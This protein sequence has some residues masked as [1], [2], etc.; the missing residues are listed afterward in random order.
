MGWSRA[1]V[2]VVLWL[3]TVHR[4][5]AAE[6]RWAVEA[7]LGGAWNAPL[8][9][10]VRQAGHPDLE[11]RARW[12]SR[13]FEPPLY[14]MVRVL[15]GDANGGWALDLTHHKLALADPPAEIA[16]F[17]ISHGY[18]LVMLHRHA[19]RNRWRYGLGGGLVVAH[20]EN[21]VRGAKLDE[22][23]GILSSGYHLTGPVIG[24][25]AAWKPLRWERGWVVLEARAVAARARVPVAAGDAGVPSLSFHLTL[26]GGWQP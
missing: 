10:T 8:A 12:E 25:L 7:H 5:A 20:P 11:G 22:S 21:E 6:S 2:A 24:A 9:W 17:A 26:G 19:E 4:E 23:G 14:Y 1:A 18:N 13:A 16:R 15:H 3:A